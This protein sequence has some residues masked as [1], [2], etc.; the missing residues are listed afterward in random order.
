[1]GLYVVARLAARY[2][3][4]VE[5]HA[6]GTGTVAYVRLPRA[7]LASPD[8]VTSTVE[9]A[10]VRPGHDPATPQLRPY[11]RPSTRSIEPARPPAARPAGGMITVPRPGADRPNGAA[12]QMAGLP[13]RHPGTD[14]APAMR[15]PAGSPRPPAPARADLLDPELVRARLSA[16][17]EG[18]SAAARRAPASHPARGT[19]DDHHP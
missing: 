11:L 14:L 3:I 2:G 9:F 19:P 6:T 8:E 10:P 16:L 4:A 13:R 15:R 1:M 12:G 18:V 17:S 5:L 7:L